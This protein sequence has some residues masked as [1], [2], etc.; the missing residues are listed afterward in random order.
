MSTVIQR[1]FAG[2]EIAPS[3]HTRVDLVKYA[4]GL[5][6]CRNCIIQ[7]HG[8][9]ANRPGTTFI[10]EV[11][12]SS[13]TVRLIPFEFNSDQTYM[14]EFGHLYMRV[15]RSGSY[16]YDLTLTIT[17]VTN[18]NPCVVSYTGTDPTNGQEF[19]ISGISGDMGPFMNGR[20][21]KITNLN[22]VAKTFE[23]QYL[24]GDAVDSLLF[25]AYNSGGTAKRV[26]TLT[27]PYVE[28][29]LQTLNYDQSGD[30][31]TITHNHYYTR[32]LSRTGHT[33]WSLDIVD[34]EPGIAA[35]TNPS[36]NGAAGTTT[37]WEITAV[38]E[39]TFEESVPSASTG[40]SATPS[41]GAPITVSWTAVTGAQEYNVYKKKNG[42]YGFIGV[43][44]STSFIDNGIDPDTDTTPPIP[45]DPFSLEGAINISAI[46]KANPGVVTTAASHG[47][48]DNDLLYIE[49]VGGMTELN[50]LFF[51]A[52]YISAT[53]FS[54]TDLEGNAIDTSAYGAYTAGGTIKPAGNFPAC[55]AYYQNRHFFASTRNN[56]EDLFATRSG[57]F[58][59]LSLRSPLQDDDA[60]QF[61]VTG[62]NVNSV[63][64]MVDLDG[65]IVFTAGGEVAIEG[66]VNG[67][68]TPGT[69]NPKKKSYIGSATLQP[70]I[71]GTTAL[72]VQAK[73]TIIRDFYNDSIE[74]FKGE[75]LSIYSAHLFEGYTIRD[76]TY[77]QIPNSIAWV[78]RDD[79]VLLGLT[80]IREHKFAAW[81][82]HD[83]DGTVEQVCSISENNEDAVYLVIKRT[84]NGE[85]KRYVERMNSRFFS[86]VLDAKFI[87]CGLSYDGRNTTAE[88]MILSGGTNWD[89]DETLTITRSIGGFTADDVGNQIFLYDEDD[90]VIRF[91]LTGFSST[92]AM[93]GT[94]HKEVPAS[95]QATATDVWSRAVDQLAGFWHLE[96]KDLSVFADRF[97]AA[98]PNNDAYEVVTVANG[99]VS[100]DQCYAVIHGGL[101]FTSDIETLDIDSLNGETLADKNKLVTDVTLVVEKTRGLFVG[102]EEPDADDDFK[103]VLTEAKIRDEEF[104]DDPVALQTGHIDVKIQS[105]W[106]SNGHV[107]IRQTDPV[108]MAILAV[109]PAGLLP[110]S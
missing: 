82:R 98:N 96:G 57:N 35:P 45:N 110:F 89:Q 11:K 77:Q 27:T 80:Y 50:S 53:T 7:K 48:I 55:S 2:G 71:I 79:G 85:E 95:L 3:L 86:D 43:A 4:T 37:E 63:R 81:H 41:G 102:G 21:F 78:V 67:V 105:H 29:D 51:L 8:G 17:N 56:P 6:T 72:I 93:T 20:N 38:A 26:Y 107:F 58:K 103:S 13:R 61:P 91:T 84:I 76:W 54:L 14:L 66:D 65:L 19:Y 62:R 5:K 88:T 73:Q 9:A 52:V 44:G 83:F 49:S 28:T 69:P 101:P 106:N 34:F 97:V 87:D 32:E 31:I 18:A 16:Q 64:S 10:G 92:T 30:I 70:L 12:D 22:T 74:G 39:E 108:P 104:Y 23:L 60:L 90:N 100:L 24:N 109:A 33:S 59:N 25:D 68:V 36:N 42:V 1:S 94:P 47:L 46:T 99:V 40:S 75:D 15:I